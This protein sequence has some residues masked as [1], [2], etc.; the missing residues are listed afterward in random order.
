MVLETSSVVF[1]YTVEFSG[2]S[3]TFN[4]SFVALNLSL[5]SDDKSVHIVT[6]FAS[7][8]VVA[9]VLSLASVSGVLVAS[10]SSSD[11]VTFITVGISLDCTLFVTSRK[12]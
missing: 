6:V 5:I 8:N 2:R 7:G 3:V 9:S 1:P 10:V 12:A 4:K 11:R